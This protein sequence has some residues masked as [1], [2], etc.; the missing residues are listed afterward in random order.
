MVLTLICSV[1]LFSKFQR[2]N[3]TNFSSDVFISYPK[4]ALRK[5]DSFSVSFSLFLSNCESISYFYESVSFFIYRNES[6]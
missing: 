6:F 1:F 4:T 3:D 5:S 2:A